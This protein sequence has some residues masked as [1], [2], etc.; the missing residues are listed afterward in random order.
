ME[1][2][3][4]I[5]AVES[6]CDETAVAI[7][8]GK[9]ILS[10][11]VLSQIKIHEIY[12]GVV[13]EIA[14]RNHT[15]FILSV[16]DESLKIAKIIPKDI[17]YVAVTN[18]PGLNGSLLVGVTA[19]LAFAYCF[20]IKVIGINHLHGHIFSALIDNEIVYPAL[21]LLVSGGHTDLIFM[22]NKLEFELLGE[23]LD[24]AVGECYDKVAKVLGLTYPGGPIIDKLSNEGKPSIIFPIPKTPKYHF[25]F[26]GLKSAVIRSFNEDPIKNIFDY[27]ASFQHTAVEILL[28]KT[29]EAVSDFSLKTIIV[30]GGV[31][32][33]STLRKVFKENFSMYNL[34]IPKISYCTDN[35]VM[36]GF[37]AKEF[38]S[39]NPDLANNKY[40]LEV[41]TTAKNKNLY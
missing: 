35:A 24:D 16:F 40:T 32:A 37:A 25:S 6:S 21:C 10:N 30:S 33:N 17:D 23:T 14:S 19:A 15:K 28:Q 3:L 38:L 27:C 5:L 18:G 8:K 4:V 36:I 12:G 22:K 9:T 34:I 41:F 1:K 20:D 13:P 26:S 31:S 2:E 7:L 11:V 29:K 39:K